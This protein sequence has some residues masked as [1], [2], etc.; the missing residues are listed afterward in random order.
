[1][2]SKT[3]GTDPQVIREGEFRWIWYKLIPTNVEIK[4]FEVKPVY[5]TLNSSGFL[6]SGKLFASFAGLNT[7]FKWGISGELTFSIRGEALPG[8][9]STY[10][11]NDQADLDAMENEYTRRVE[12]YLSQRLINY[13]EDET[14][15]ENAVLYGSSPELAGEIQAA[16]PELENIECR[17]QA[18]EIPDYDLYKVLKNVYNEYLTYQNA[19]LQDSAL[20]SADAMVELRF[21][22]DE[23]EKYGEILEKYPILMQ[24]LA[25]EKGFMLNSNGNALP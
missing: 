2:R 20:R 15:M 16:F 1:M 8:M 14:N 3:H 18:V 19:I 23:L 24:Y 10:N 22:I 17:I 5:H 6:P 9:A 11:M 12:A 21:R 4:V 7:D 13:G 25:L